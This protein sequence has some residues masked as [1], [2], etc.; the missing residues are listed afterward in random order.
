MKKIKKAYRDVRDFFGGMSRRKIPTFAGAGAYYLF[1]SLVPMIMLLCALLQYT[2]LTEE[3]VLAVLVDYVPH[4][5]YELVAD[6]VATVYSG[7]GVALTVSIALTVWSASA[8][9]KALMRGMDS[10]YDAERRESYIGFSLRACLYMLVFLLMLMLSFF[11]MVYGGKILRL[12][13][14]Y[15]PA[16]QALTFLLYRLQKLRFIIV[17]AVLVL[18]FMLLYRWMPATPTRYRHQWPGAI[19]TSMA[20][21]VFSWGFSLY[22]SMSDKLGAYGFLGTIIIAMM[23]MY[24]CLYFLLLGGYINRYVDLRR[25][26]RTESAE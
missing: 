22:V 18:V 13:E 23:W 8:S 5:M 17:M 1:M 16:A 26:P 11:V 19:F 15:V 4:S 7:G 9:M 10:V 3:L 14:I 12:I 25:P 24:F 2:P 20:W 6:I 21:V